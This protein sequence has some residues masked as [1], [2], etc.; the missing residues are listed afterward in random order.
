MVTKSS[1]TAR[2]ALVTG[3]SSGIGEELARCFAKGGYALVLVARSADKL[4]SLAE[5]LQ[6]EH[7]IGG[8]G[9]CGRA[10]QGVGAQARHH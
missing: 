4:Q 5:E 3:A 6:R 10:G 2:V 1:R 9:H 8:A 7:G